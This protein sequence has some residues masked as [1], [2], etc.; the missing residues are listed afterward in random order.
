MNIYEMM[1]QLKDLQ[2]GFEEVKGVLSSRREVLEREGVEV[3]FNGLGEVL[4][5][6][7]KNGDLK[8][9]WERLRPVLLDLL[10]EVHLRSKD[11][12]KEEF[13]KRFGGLLGGLGLG[14]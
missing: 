9:D 10:R 2:K 7:V 3:T 11:M 4:D 14:L 8:E 6:R 5:I 1:K 13:G 12:A